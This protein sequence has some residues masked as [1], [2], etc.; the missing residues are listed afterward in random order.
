[1]EYL[2]DPIWQFVGAIFALIAIAVTGLVF[3]LQKKIKRISYSIELDTRMFSVR[4]ELEGKLKITYQKKRVKNIRLLELKFI[5]SGNL[6]VAT[7]DYERPITV[8]FGTSANILSAEISETEPNNLGVTI[9][10]EL[11]SFTLSPTLLNPKDSIKIK[12]LL[13]N[14]SGSFNIDTRIIGVST[15]KPVDEVTVVGTLIS[16]IGLSISLLG[17][18]SLFSFTEDKTK[19]PDTLRIG[20]ALLGYLRGAV[21]L[22]IGMRTNRKFRRLMSLFIRPLVKELIRK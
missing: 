14:Y 9:A 5:N 7:S 4:E 20:F 1:M 6:P 17:V 18:I 8:G 11:N 21:L 19:S 22:S 2:R 15:I 13:N 16:L 12:L 10:T 3:K